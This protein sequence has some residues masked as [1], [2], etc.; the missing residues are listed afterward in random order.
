LNQCQTVRLVVYHRRDAGPFVDRDTFRKL[1]QI[2]GRDDFFRIQ[3]HKDKGPIL[4][5]DDKRP[6][7][8][9]VDG[10]IDGVFACRDRARLPGFRVNDR[11]GILLHVGCHNKPGI[12][13]HVYGGGLLL[14][15]KRPDHGKCVCIDDRNVA[16]QAVDDQGQALLRRRPRRRFQNGHVDRLRPCRNRG[17]HLP[18]V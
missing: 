8:R 10:G 1:V 11:D 5:T 15:G 18:H 17:N 13:I 12:R 9:G 14:K 7:A 2:K 16:V 4:V 6:V 3:I